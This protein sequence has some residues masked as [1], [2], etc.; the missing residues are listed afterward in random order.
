M[1][2]YNFPNLTYEE[3]KKMQAA[4][5]WEEISNNREFNLFTY[6]KRSRAIHIDFEVLMTSNEMKEMVQKT[7]LCTWNNYLNYI[8][9]IT[10]GD[11]KSMKHYNEPYFNLEIREQMLLPAVAKILGKV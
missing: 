7:S 8:E 11:L 3:K 1:L 9:S 10:T 4:M 6:L 2:R 5:I